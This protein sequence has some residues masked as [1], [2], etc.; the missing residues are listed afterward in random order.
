MSSEPV[1]PD[2]AH[3]CLLPDARRRPISNPPN[4][5]THLSSSWCLHV[6]HARF[7]SSRRCDSSSTVGYTFDVWVRFRFGQQKLS[8]MF[9]SFVHIVFL[10]CIMYWYKNWII[11]NTSFSILLDFYV[12]FLALHDSSYVRHCAGSIPVWRPIFFLSYANLAHT[13]TM[14]R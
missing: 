1:C 6:W 9:G 7:R 8:D 4:T 11:C 2:V 10:T 13:H 12:V 14:G 5:L 3:H